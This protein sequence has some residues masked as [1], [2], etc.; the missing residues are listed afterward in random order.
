MHRQVGHRQLT[1]TRRA[2]RLAL[3]GA[4]LGGGVWPGLPA[5]AQALSLDRHLPPI[6]ER[7]QEDARQLQAWLRKNVQPWSANRADLSMLATRL[8][9]ADVVGL[10]EIT[11]GSHEDMA[12]KAELIKAL[13]EQQGARM[14]ALEANRAVGLRLQR[15]IEPASTE[16]DV[17]AAL[18]ESG[19]FSVYRCEAL[20]ELLLWLQAWNRHA[21]SPVRVL[22]IDVQDP[23]RDLK[24]ALDALSPLD[25]DL[26]TRLGQ[27]LQEL[28]G[29]RV[30]HVSVLFPTANRAQ[31][32]R[33]SAAAKE[34]E[35]ALQ[36]LRASDDALDA[37]YA[38]RM[39]LYTFEFD[40]GT[41]GAP[42]DLPPE[43]FTRR[44]V[45][46]AERLLRGRHPGEHA[47]LWAHDTHVASN[48]YDMFAA[49]APTVGKVL[50]DRLGPD[51]YQSLNFSY[52]QASFHAHGLNEDGTVDMK[53]PFRLWRISAGPG[54]LGA[55][56]AAAGA[57]SFWVDLGA[58]PGDRWAL[59]FRMEPYR[60]L[61]FGDG[62]A[63]GQMAAGDVS[64]PL[65]YGTDI[66]VHLD[67][68]TP[69]RLYGAKVAAPMPDKDKEKAP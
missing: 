51:G 28:R 56:M 30:P 23:A 3:L 42:T 46:M 49:Q 62:V 61:A 18:R 54:S 2:L 66:L 31:W 16:T 7:R 59:S 45:A 21:A 58:L 15:F 69:S 10:G 17:Q 67:T 50:R 13:V 52:R 5:M 65:N 29:E 64:W 12:F 6:E 47:L 60:R 9:S 55:A 4:C 40:V 38:T 14:L 26:A 41:A 48:G 11:H 19:I 43:A 8:G 57:H 24:A 36:R 37:A 53:G 63:P 33:W 1:R 39:A 27:A 68:L 22:G 25:S 20:G 34:L 35:A 44:D 32:Q